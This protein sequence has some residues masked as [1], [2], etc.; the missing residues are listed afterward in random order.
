VL[1]IITMTKGSAVSS[2]L[3]RAWFGATNQGESVD[4]VALCSNPGLAFFDAPAL[5]SDG[6]QAGIFV[7]ERLSYSQ[8]AVRLDR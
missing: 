2:W 6:L 5:V 4:R 7:V 8:D 3:L 1:Q